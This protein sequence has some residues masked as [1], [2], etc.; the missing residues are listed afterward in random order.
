MK[1]RRLDQLISSLG[2]GSRREVALLLRAERIALHGVPLKDASLKVD[3]DAVTFDAAPLEFPHGLL[4][5][6]H[7]PKGVVCS[8]DSREGH[9]IYDLLPPRWL[10]RNPSVTSIGRLDKETSG[11]LLL[12]DVGQLVQQ[13]TS[14]KSRV[15][16]TYLAQLDRS[17]SPDDIEAF[18]Q[19]I[20]LKGEDDKCL[21]AKLTAVAERQA[22]VVI[23]EGK[24][25]QVRRMFAARGLFVNELHRTAVGH[26][27]LDDLK[28]G[29]WKALSL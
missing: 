17:V 2:Y 21:P 27:A 28:P 20:S 4:V 5:A 6:L 9:R 15:E 24:Y 29:E 19:G 10:L 18:A 1:L 12:T 7:K 11:L 25:H 16:K 14:P 26:L 23:C 22:K 3:P 8:H 13:M